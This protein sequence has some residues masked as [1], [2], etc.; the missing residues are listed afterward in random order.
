MKYGLRLA[1]GRFEVKPAAVVK[2]YDVAVIVYQCA[3]HALT[4]KQHLLDC[5]AGRF[6][7]RHL[8]FPLGKRGSGNSPKSR[9]SNDEFTNTII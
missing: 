4:G 6:L 8:L 2:K 9:Y 5:L 7:H 1:R 3:G